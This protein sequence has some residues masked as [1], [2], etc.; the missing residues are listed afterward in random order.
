MPRHKI[1]NPRNRILPIR[2]SESEWDEVSKQAGKMPLSQWIRQQ[3]LASME[4][5]PS[6]TSP[7][8]HSERLPE[9]TPEGEVPAPLLGETYT[10]YQRRLDHWSVAALNDRDLRS[11][12]ALATAALVKCQ[13]TR[14]GSRKV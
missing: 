11:R 12:L 1:R 5:P 6:S 13:S 7:A 14:P 2:F 3:A 4:S 8:A 10:D 9:P